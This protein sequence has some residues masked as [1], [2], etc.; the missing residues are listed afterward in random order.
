MPTAR[1]ATP[2]EQNAI[3]HINAVDKGA[4]FAPVQARKVAQAV[5][6]QIPKATKEKPVTTEDI[7]QILR[8]Y[9]GNLKGVLAGR[10]RQIAPNVFEGTDTTV[11][12]KKEERVSSK[13]PTEE[14]AGQ[15]G[16]TAGLDTEEDKPKTV[17]ELTTAANVARGDAKKSKVTKA[18]T[19]TKV[20]AGVKIAKPVTYVKGYERTK[21]PSASNFLNQN[22]YY[23][24]E[25]PVTVERGIETGAL[26]EAFDLMDST[27]WEKG[28]AKELKQLAAEFNKDKKAKDRVTAEKPL[29]FMT[30]EQLIKIYEKYV[31]KAAFDAGGAAR[32]EAQK[33]R[34]AFIK[35]LTP[36]QRQLFDKILAKAFKNEVRTEALGR[37][38]ATGRD[39]RAQ[40]ADDRAKIKTQKDIDK[41]Y[42]AIEQ[43]KIDAETTERDLER[44]AALDTIEEE[45]SLLV[46][47]KETEQ[48]AKAGQEATVEDVAP[49]TT[50]E[51]DSDVKAADKIE[52]VEAVGPE[53]SKLNARRNTRTVSAINDSGDIKS[54]LAELGGGETDYISV[55]AS[56]LSKV[57]KHLK[58]TDPTLKR[59][60]FSMNIPDGKDGMFDPKRNR[61]FI[62]GENGKY[63]GKRPLEEVLEHEILHYYTDHVVDNRTAY[64]EAIP[65]EDRPAATAA[66]NRLNL[67]YQRAKAALGDKFN[68]DS[69][70]EFIAEAFSNKEFQNALKNLDD[71][72]RVYKPTSKSSMFREF[73]K[74]IAA[75][76][77]LSDPS[78]AVTFKEVLEDIAQILDAPGEGLYGREVSYATSKSKKTQQ[79]K[80]APIPLR[81]GDIGIGKKGEASN[82]EYMPPEE[83][84]GRDKGFWRKLFTTSEGWQNVARVFQNDR[85]PIKSWQDV[86]ELAG[87]IVDD[88]SKNFNNIYT[89]IT[90]SSGRAKD[91]YERHVAGPAQALD[92][93]INNFAKAT[94]LD[95]KSAIAQLHMITEAIHEKERREAKYIMLV[96]LS[97]R[98]VVRFNGKL[99]S[100]AARRQQIVGEHDK[101]IKG[102]L[103]NPKL[104][105]AEAKQLR[106]ELDFLVKKYT[107]ETGYSPSGI[108]VAVDGNKRKNTD[109]D[110]EAYNVVGVDPDTAE[111]RRVEIA[112]SKFKPQ[113]DA[114]SAALKG[115]HDATKT[116]DM[117]SNYWSKPVSNRVAFYGFENYIPL[118]GRKGEKVTTIDE[119][120][121]FT[122]SRMGSEVDKPQSAFGG[123]MSVATNPLLQSMS[124]ATR[125]ALRAGRKNI[126]QSIINA[127]DQGLLNGKAEYKKEPIPFEQRYAVVPDENTIFHYAENGDITLIKIKDKLLLNSIR[128]TYKAVNPLVDIANNITSMIGQ[129]HTRYNYSFG[130]MN[131][132]RDILTNAF[133]MGAD[134][135]PTKSLAL[136]G[137]ISAKV[138][139]GGLGKAMQFIALYNRKDF[140]S[141]ENLAKKDPFVR[142]MLDFYTEGGMVTY[143]DGI[144]IKSNFESL[145]KELGRGGIMKTK[146]QVDKFVD[147]WTNMFELASRASAYGVAK[148]SFM[149]DG[150]AEQ[151]ART[152]AAAYA[153]N[154]ANFEQ[155]GQ[156]GKTM[157]AF[158]MFFRPAATG[159]VRAIEALTPAFR[160]LDSALKSLP[161]AIQIGATPEAKAQRDTFIKNYKQKQKNA[162]IMTGA[163]FGL[164]MTAYA[165]SMAMSPEDELG[166]NKVMTDN[167]QQWSRY[168]RFHL[169]DGLGLGKDVVFQIPWGFGLGAFAAAGA[170]MAAVMFGK[171]TVA[172][173]AANIALQI[174]L[175]SFIPIPVS[176]MNPLEDPLNFALDSIAPSTVRPV[177]EF[178]LNKNGLGQGIYNDS[179]RRIGDAYVGGDN[180]PQVYKDIARTFAQITNGGVDWS[181]NSMYFLANSYA[182]G[183]SRIF[184]TTYG[185]TDLASG[186]KEFN[187]KTDLPLAGSFFGTRSNVDSRE[188]SSVEKKILAKE[189]RLNMFKGDPQAMMKYHSEY[190][191]D[192]AIV[193]HFN[194]MVNGELKRLRTEAK[195]FRL[196]EGI[197]P[198]EREAMV[199]MLTLQQNL[200]KNN[201]IETFKAYDIKP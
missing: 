196:M 168:A 59:I 156:V 49:E 171:S 107:D 34:A 54:V 29:D 180:I 50:S 96:P 39:K 115:L 140:A 52:N 178:A 127:I 136:I 91:L 51:E 32:V 64:L 139:N 1:E 155:V 137:D 199:K 117:Q 31:G 86:L 129:F 176:K 5:G 105:V 102:E 40:R 26:D 77:G 193:K 18:G 130:P 89:Q 69:L 166:R 116:L 21:E 188:F 37:R 118:K 113:I 99:I 15:V 138:A 195:N 95:I 73:V 23:G 186:R 128:R 70:K 164:G 75:A 149:A 114:V 92:T 146:E 55:M 3:N 12:T 68:I 93:A 109:I 9:V 111:A 148:R 41:Y 16:S 157:G 20:N 144:A 158:Y 169:P 197:T 175:D 84:V 56:K 163:L 161:Q 74:N 78:S 87:A 81:T 194:T 173:A 145:Q 124:D 98:A 185:L 187:A 151:P 24:E 28:V 125:S 44:D 97:Q 11:T 22:G 36:E 147:I 42:D 142:D 198:K 159:A 65:A 13:L 38:G 121:D 150:M 190:P 103:D 80:K 2:E 47:E 153:K 63:T 119:M 135:G 6:I 17:A 174:S 152:K 201:I 82:A 172:D 132:V 106:A 7:N 191:M 27:L 177:L 192:E 66:L 165:M 110:N 58:I 184:E 167:M 126:T 101:N 170:Q 43:R 143:I 67:N 131:F 79:T 62:R 85:Y 123:R 200:I 53:S 4:K 14:P 71:A 33:N 94:G 154:L 183:V 90:L 162:R 112:G 141:I 122:S 46:D 72:G 88:L 120:L 104:T 25:A 60:S 100:P 48:A 61:I 181:P 160:S 35:S 189:Q 179:N 76:F 19:E 8:E 133:T 83:V 134:L 30:L 182:D 108:K 10:I 57:L 45:Q